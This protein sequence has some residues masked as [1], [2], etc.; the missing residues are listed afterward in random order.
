MP[1]DIDTGNAA[2]AD[3]PD[4]SPAYEADKLFIQSP[5]AIAWYTTSYEGGVYSV[6]IPVPEPPTAFPVSLSLLHNL[7]LAKRWMKTI[8]MAASHQ[9][10]DL[11]HAEFGSGPSRPAKRDSDRTLLTTML[12]AVHPANS[13]FE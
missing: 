2:L 9:R 11:R 13:A 6:W 12:N 7:T 3:A 10:L 8:A 4:L 5:Q 1:I